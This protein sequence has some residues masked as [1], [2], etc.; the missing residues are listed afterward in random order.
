MQKIDIILFLIL[1]LNKSKITITIN[2]LFYLIEHLSLIDIIK[3]KFV[4]I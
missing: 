3:D 1:S 2:I 4:L